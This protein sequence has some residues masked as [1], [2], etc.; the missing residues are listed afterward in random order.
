[1]KGSERLP[2]SGRRF[3]SI[4]DNKDGTADVY[5]RPDGATGF[6]LV[7]GVNLVEGLE[8]DIRERFYDW[9]ASG[10]PVPL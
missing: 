4:L 7:R 10:E 6:I 8:R 3:Y 2:S 5:L 9:C 1:M